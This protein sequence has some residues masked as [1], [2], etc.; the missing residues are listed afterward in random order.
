[1][2]KLK[3]GKKVSLIKFQKRNSNSTS[4]WTLFKYILKQKLIYKEVYIAP[5]HDNHRE[6][7]QVDLGFQEYAM[8]HLEYPEIEVKTDLSEPLMIEVDIQ[9][10]VDERGIP[11][12]IKRFKDG[13][14]YSRTGSKKKDLLK[15][16]NSVFVKKAIKIINE[17]E[18]WKPFSFEGEYVEKRFHKTIY[19]NY[20]PN[21]FVNQESLVL[22]PDTRARFNGEVDLYD[23]I[24][25]AK[26]SAD[27]IMNLT[28]I[29]N[30][31]GKFVEIIMVDCGGKIGWDM[32]IS[33]LKKLEPL[34]PAVKDNM[35][36]VSSL[37]IVLYI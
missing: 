22:N 18:G 37:D 25:K 6:I 23:R 8:Y 36:V 5:E 26:Y 28:A 31:Q 14:G 10:K 3:N 19:F 30:E 2:I 7:D 20:H 21:Y 29:V 33:Q 16:D 27:G 13:I 4:F 9:F 35:T 15:T 1:M 17:F 24:I 32:A 34:T 12:D 11:F